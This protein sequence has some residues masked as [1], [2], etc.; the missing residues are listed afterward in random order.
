MTKGNMKLEKKFI[1]FFINNDEFFVLENI[2]N[3]RMYVY[4]VDNI[5]ILY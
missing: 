1:F 5:R 2:I 3:E 4:I